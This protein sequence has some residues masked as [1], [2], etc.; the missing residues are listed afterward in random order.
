GELKAEEV[1]IALAEKP[2]DLD[3]VAD[4]FARAGQSPVEGDGRV[5]QTVNRQALGDEVD[6]QI[7]G[8]EQV[9]LTRLDRDRGR[10]SAGVEVPVAA[11]DVVLGDDPPARKRPRLALD[12]Q[13]PVYQ[14]ERLV[15]K[16]HPRGMAVDRGILMSQHRGNRAD[17]KLQALCAVEGHLSV[18]LRQRGGGSLALRWNSAREG[19]DQTE[20]IL[21]VPADQRSVVV[22]DPEKHFVGA[23]RGGL[24]SHELTDQWR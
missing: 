15:G 6:A 4:R 10:D 13:Y 17:G 2:R 3:V 8:E 24:G 23:G 22:R 9:R 18:P 16:P 14:H 21:Q 11:K 19:L 7:A 1:R 20:L 5:E 12:R